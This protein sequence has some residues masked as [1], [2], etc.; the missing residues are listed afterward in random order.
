MSFEPTGE[1]SNNLR[2]VE[3]YKVS[4]NEGDI[5]QVSGN[6]INQK[7]KT[8]M[9]NCRA[10]GKSFD[11]TFAV[12]DFERLSVDQSEAGTLHICAHCGDLGLY[13]MKDYF[14]TA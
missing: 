12:E 1:T 7:K 5:S 13:R 10:C 4:V 9:V 8:M 14:E 11:T 3:A 2:K 6:T